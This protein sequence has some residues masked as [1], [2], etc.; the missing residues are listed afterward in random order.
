MDLIIVLLLLCILIGIRLRNKYIE[1]ELWNNGVC[2]CGG[3]FHKIN[4]NSKGG[5]MYICKKCHKYIEIYD[6]SIDK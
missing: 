2:E 4:Y 6:N 3:K 5:R 1:K